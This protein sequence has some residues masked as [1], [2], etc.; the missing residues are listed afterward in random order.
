MTI[1][2]AIHLH[3]F[4]NQIYKFNKNF[5]TSNDKYVSTQYIELRKK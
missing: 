3:N 1:V 5:L 2:R 4:H